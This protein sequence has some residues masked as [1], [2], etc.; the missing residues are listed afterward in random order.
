MKTERNPRFSSAGLHIIAMGFMLCDHLWAML[1]TEWKWLTWIGR[2]AFPIFAFLLVEGFF[3]TKNLK[4]YMLRLLFLAVLTEIPFNL[5]CA[6]SMIYPFHQ[7]VI[8][9]FLLG[10]GLMNLLEKAKVSGKRW[11]WMLTAVPV[12]F[13]GYIAG[14]ITMVDYNGGGILMLLTFYFFRGRKWWNY[15]GQAAAMYY[16]NTEIL[17]GLYYPVRILGREYELVEQSLA[18]LALIPIWLYNGTKGIQNRAF[19]VLCYGFYPLHILVLY[20]ISV[21]LFR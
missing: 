9:T 3:H 16:I 11:R 10:L 15:V 2:L 20:G 17:G 12:V 1:L 13:L 6:D 19:R 7:N 4:R 21:I 18:V 5:M 8:W 14:M